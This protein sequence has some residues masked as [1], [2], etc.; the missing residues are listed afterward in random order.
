MGN[1]GIP[2]HSEIFGC[3]FGLEHSG[4][5]PKY[6]KGE[7]SEYSKVIWNILC[8]WNFKILY[9][10]HGICKYLRHVPQAP[11]SRIHVSYEL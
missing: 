1:S 9:K 10:K 7:I 11:T 6:N 4:I 8:G 2:R 5:P 3:F